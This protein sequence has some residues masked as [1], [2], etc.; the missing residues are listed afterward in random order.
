MSC[1]LP[2]MPLPFQMLL[3]IL[4]QMAVFS[5]ALR[6]QGYASDVLLVSIDRES[7]PDRIITALDTAL[8]QH[9]WGVEGQISQML[10]VWTFK[11][12]RSSAMAVQHVK[13]GLESIGAVKVVQ[14]D[15]YIQ[16]RSAPDTTIWPNDPVLPE[17]WQLHNTGQNGGTPGAD[18]GMADAWDLSTGGVSPSG[19]TIVVAVID[20][21]V[22]AN[23]ADLMG[24]L[25]KNYQEVPDDG[26]DNDGNGYT[27]DYLGWN[28]VL[29]NDDISG[30]S[31]H[32]G[33]PIT[34]II[35]ARTNNSLGVAGLNWNVKTL[36]V[37]GK[38]Q[39]SALLASFDYI[40][41]MR[42]LYNETNGQKGA[43]IVALNCSW[44][45]DYGQPSEAPLWCQAFDA[46]GL[47]GIVSVGATAN[48]AVNVDLV[49]DLPTACPSEYLIG[50]TSIN[51][52][53]KRASNAAWGPVHV[54]LAA[55]GAGVVTVKN[56]N[57]YGPVSGT[58]FAAPQVTGTIALLYAEACPNLSSIAMS[59]PSAAASWTK[60]LILESTIHV[61]DLQGEVGSSGRLDTYNVLS[62]YDDLCTDC[63]APFAFEWEQASPDSV[64][65]SWSET[66]DFSQ[67]NFRWREAGQGWNIELDVESP[68]LLTGL[69]S[70]SEYNFALRSNCYGG[71]FST[72]SMAQTFETGNCCEAPVY[73]WYDSLSTNSVTLHWEQ[74]ASAQEYK[75]EWRTGL[76]AWEELY[77]LNNSA[78]L[79]SLDSC[80]LY[81]CRIQMKCDS[82]WTIYS[83]PYF[84][85]TTGCGACLDVSYCEATSENGWGEWIQTVKIGN[86]VHHTAAGSGGYQDFSGTGDTILQLHAGQEYPVSIEPGF[87]G[88]ALKQFFRIYI[89]YNGD[90]VFSNPEELAFDPGFTHNGEV[91]GT[92]ITPDTFTEGITRMRVILKYEGPFEEAPLP[93]EEFKFGEVEDYCVRLG[94][95]IVNVELPQSSSDLRLFPNPAGNWINVVLQSGETPVRWKLHDMTGGLVAGGAFNKTQEQLYV[96]NLSV[97]VYVLKLE[98]ADKWIRRLVLIQR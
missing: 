34:G 9:G 80:T 17:Q 92:L 83:K 11:R 75:V 2:K 42:K 33:T 19:D 89:D 20:G 94:G 7:D 69:K 31:T 10:N 59:N 3:A 82:G 56:N 26:M 28:A 6:A 37:A 18:L 45:V 77:T 53:E 87:M 79:K 35:G 12:Q 86:W 52:K 60:S 96:G 23:H 48:L 43:F 40:W 57:T 44:G 67:V 71:T 58:S 16:L 85:Q 73:I 72:W 49:G 39:E 27:D 47:Q 68:F 8:P 64:W 74:N 1:I 88:L 93:C 63:P 4:V 29:N 21:G 90:G 38:G 24:N 78:G 97:G 51:N 41:T 46:L 15:H 54:D 22:Q 66:T 95:P 76:G 50:V 81:E 55:F 36:F 61:A 25:W 70:C 13:R 32:H 98:L 84:I 62:H 91:S 30:T 5:T 14:F 65:I